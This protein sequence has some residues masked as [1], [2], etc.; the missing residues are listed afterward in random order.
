MRAIASWRVTCF[1]TTTE[2]HFFRFFCNVFLWRKL[3]AFMTAITE[4][5]IRTLTTRTPKIR[6]A[7][8]YFNYVG[9][10]L[11]CFTLCHDYPGRSFVSLLGDNNIDG[12]Y[13]PPLASQRSQ[14]Q[15]KRF[16]PSA[17]QITARRREIKIEI[18][19]IQV[20]YVSLRIYSAFLL[21]EN[22][23]QVLAQYVV[24]S[25]QSLNS[26]FSN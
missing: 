6:F 21:H 26:T 16:N 25:L 20:V 19:I 3:S 1:T 9:R 14:P 18:E 11:C 24:S 15:H 13:Q 12:A 8:G 7:F 4:W 10:V 17:G 22:D 2:S 23:F 5:L